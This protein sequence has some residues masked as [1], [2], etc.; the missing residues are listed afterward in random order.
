[1]SQLS[2][3]VPAFNEERGLAAVLKRV[4]EAA[5]QVR[6][7]HPD[8]TAVEVIVVDDG[9]TDSTA[10]VAGAMPAVSLIRHP[11]NRGYGAA[12]KTGFARAQ[13]EYLAFLDADA[14]YPPETLP[15]LVGALLERRAD[16]VVGARIS[17]PD[18]GMPKI[19]A[20]GNWLFARL[21]SWVIEARVTD[22]ASG[23]RV[24]RRAILDDILDLPDGFNFIVAM[25]TVTMHKGLRVVEVPIP[26]FSRVGESKLRVITDGLAFLSSIVGVAISYNPLKFI[27]PLG[28]A[29]IVA[30]LY[31]SIDPILY[32]LQNRRVEDDELYRLIT[33]SV[34][35]VSGLHVINFGLFSNALLARSLGEAPDRR[36]V[37]GR[38]LLRSPIMRLGGVLGPA[39]CLGAVVLNYRALLQYLTNGTIQEHWSYVLTGGSL[40]LVGLQLMMSGLLLRIVGIRTE[41]RRRGVRDLPGVDVTPRAVDR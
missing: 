33:I 18:G 32:Y 29:C 3:V 15:A 21:L 39:L 41:K 13:G 1:M 40:F 10:A 11:A 22:C 37:L 34:L 30:A 24:F 6:R 38:L 4:L 23:I 28:M 19:R 2:V 5:E 27:G 35:A 7:Q 25:S 8:I 12:L 17:D 31:L 14:T 20:L 26:Y 16:V 9:S 36:S